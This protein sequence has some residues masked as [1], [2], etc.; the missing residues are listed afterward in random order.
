MKD[1][2]KNNIQNNNDLDDLPDLEDF[3]E[4]LKKMNIGKINN[5][6]VSIP[7]NINNN[8]NNLYDNTKVGIPIKISNNSNNSES[9]DMKNNKAENKD[10]EYEFGMGLKKGFLNKKINDNSSQNHIKEKEKGEI[11]DLTNIKSKNKLEIDEVQQNM[12]NESSSK[13]SKFLLNNIMNNKDQWLNEE[14]MKKLMKNPKL[15]QAFTHPNFN[16][17]ITLIQKD[18][19]EAK[20]RYGNVPEL[21]EFFKEFSSLMA[22]HFNN[23]EKK[24]TS[25]FLEEQSKKDEE[26]KK[27]LEDPK[28]NNLLKILHKEGKLDPIH[29][30]NDNDLLIKFNILIDKGVLKTIPKN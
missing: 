10:K 5:E 19:N 8:N 24:Q 6:K 29:F 26:I 27:I 9:R 21:N 25:N 30:E 12:K 3:S 23:L 15:L 2:N 17:V 1:N 4:D 28:V 11:V 16:D 7:V 13:D 18:P 22:D 14:L 20:K